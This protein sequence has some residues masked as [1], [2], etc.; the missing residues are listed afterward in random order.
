MSEA[1]LK[2]TGLTK[3]FQDHVILNDLN[4]EIQQGEVVV[5]VGPSG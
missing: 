3:Q 4:L 2:I 5:V 1:L